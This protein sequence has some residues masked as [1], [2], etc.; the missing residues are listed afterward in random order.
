MHFA[1]AWPAFCFCRLWFPSACWLNK[2]RH[3]TRAPTFR[4][5]ASALSSHVKVIAY[6]DQRFHDH[7]NFLIANPKARIAL[8]DKI[9]QEKPDAVQM[10]GDVPFKGTDPL[11]LRLLPHRDASLAR[12][13]PQ[14][15]SRTGQPRTLR[16]RSQKGVEEWWNAFPELKGM[17]WYSVALGDRIA[18]IELDSTSDLTPGSKQLNWLRAQLAAPASVRRLRDDQSAPSARRGYPDPSACRPQPAPK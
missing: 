18:L 2:R 5:D 13:P 3:P 8:A 12:R 16:R 9:A 15:L 4:V 7:S 14:R 6:G 1:P 10:S 17:R 11:R